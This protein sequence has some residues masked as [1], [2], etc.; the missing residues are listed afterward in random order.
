MNLI[1]KVA[2]AICEAREQNGGPPYDAFDAIYGEK[3]A[4]RLRGHLF[5]EAEAAILDRY[6]EEDEVSVH[7]I[8]EPE[9][10]DE[11]EGNKDE[12]DDEE[13]CDD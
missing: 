9:E 11:E 3:G 12:T 13:D 1:E 8:E 10:E 4:R 5:E 2:R 6:T 7:L